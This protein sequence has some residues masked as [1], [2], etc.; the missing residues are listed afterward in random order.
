MSSI[1]SV[2]ILC[3]TDRASV[4]GAGEDESTAGVGQS[5]ETAEPG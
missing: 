4:S 5:P 3:G 2:E 1:S